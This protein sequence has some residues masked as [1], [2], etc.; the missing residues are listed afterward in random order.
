MQIPKAIVPA[1]TL[2][3]SSQHRV[4]QITFH[5]SQPYVAVQSHDRSVEIFRIR[6]EDEIRKKQARRR[7]RAKEKKEK[8][9][10]KAKKEDEAD[11]LE[12]DDEGKVDLVDLFTPYLV[13]RA[14]G[15][16]RSFGFESEE[17]TS[18]GG[19]QVCF[20]R[21]RTLF[22]TN[23]SIR[24]LWRCRTMP[25]KFT[26]SRNRRRRRRNLQKPPGYIRWT[27]PAIGPTCAHFA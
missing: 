15:K 27:C 10:G 8:T 1:A 9:K 23:L 11:P 7:K 25:W 19:T 4:S 16:I 24:Y 6:T 20:F 3:L 2:P 13:V 22:V 18:K 21:W 17:A 12:D 26:T 5:P 14:T